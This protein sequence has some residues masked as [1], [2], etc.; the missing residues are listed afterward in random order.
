[1]QGSNP[2][3]PE[4]EFGP[5]QLFPM[6]LLSGRKLESKIIHQSPVCNHKVKFSSSIPGKYIVTQLV[7]D[8]RMFVFQEFPISELGTSNFIKIE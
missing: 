7:H 1:M 3:E 2:D 4:F 5:K 8:K 6:L